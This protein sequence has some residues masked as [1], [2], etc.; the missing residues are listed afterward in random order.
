MFHMEQTFTVLG[1]PHAK[2]RPRFQRMGRFVRVYSLDG[3]L[4]GD[5]AKLVRATWCNPPLEGP[6]SLSLVYYLP[7]P[8]HTA[9]KR[10][11]ALEGAYQVRKPDADNYAKFTMDALNGLLYQDDRQVAVL[12]I[13][14]RYSATPRTEITIKT[15]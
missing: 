5:L 2:R 4:E 8:K 14:K 15:L 9:K 3:K 10:L 6:I 12:R 11:A 1:V 7:I 13:E